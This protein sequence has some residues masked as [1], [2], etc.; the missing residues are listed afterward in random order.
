M[1]KC[2]V[3]LLFGVL[4]LLGVAAP[5][6]SAADPVIGNWTL[7]PKLSKYDPGPAPKGQTREYS[8]TPEGTRVT[9]TTT[10]NDGTITI[11]QYDS[12]SDGKDYPV[13]GESEAD[14]VALTKVSDFVSQATLKHGTRVIAFVLREISDDGKTMTLTYTG[15]T[16]ARG[17]EQRVSNRAVYAK[18]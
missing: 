7:I 11:F 8:V 2:F 13:T 4:V 17:Y 18:Q 15:Y 12:N 3:T 10:R 1:A 14:A 9:V 6:A 16:Q 5:L